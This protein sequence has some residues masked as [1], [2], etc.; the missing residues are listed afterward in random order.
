M[1]TSEL[2]QQK[3]I[4][5]IGVGAIFRFERTL[6]TSSDVHYHHVIFNLPPRI[7]DDS[8][9]LA[10]IASSVRYHQNITAHN[11]SSSVLMRT[12]LNI[13][14]SQ[15]T[16]LRQAVRNIYD[17]IPEFSNQRNSKRSFQICWVCGKASAG[18]WGYAMASDVEDLQSLVEQ[19]NN[20]TNQRLDNIQQSLN[21]L[22]SYSKINDKKI[23][24]LATVT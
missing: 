10:K 8:F 5:R 2:L 17:T 14:A 4:N 13:V 6:Q 9:L 19:A 7:F 11:A 12:L 24:A 21:A 23:Q 15:T 1:G 16:Y 18:F 22:A 3:T 20:V